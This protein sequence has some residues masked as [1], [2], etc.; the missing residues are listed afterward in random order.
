[1]ELPRV[2]IKT[3]LYATDL[4]ESAR[5]AF[6]YAASLADLYHARLFILHVIYE[7]RELDDKVRGYV[8]PE[9]WNRIKEQH[10]ADA[11][12]TLIGKQRDHIAIRD[13]LD[14]FRQQAG[15]E[16]G[17]GSIEM[18]E[19]IVERGDPIEQI[20]RVSEEQNIDLI[21]MGRHGYGVLKDALMGGVARGVL[22]HSSKP[23]LLVKLP[24]E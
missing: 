14:Q 17:A 7:D 15:N 13:V 5:Q 6:A 11:R 20:I 10:L 4:S 8:S 21:V 24:E 19:I 23:V 2:E 16:L 1:M 22:R 3:I 18:D 12:E 9:Q